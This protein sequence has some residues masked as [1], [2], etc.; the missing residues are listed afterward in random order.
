LGLGRGK[1]LSQTQFLAFIEQLL[2][3][4]FGY[5]SC[6]FY[7]LLGEV[8]A[9]GDFVLVVGAFGPSQH[10]TRFRKRDGAFRAILASG[11]ASEYVKRALSNTSLCVDQ[12]ERIAMMSSEKQRIATAW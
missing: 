8:G 5:G 3:L 1:L 11:W 7:F 12:P 2:L 6:D 9:M 10:A 4:G